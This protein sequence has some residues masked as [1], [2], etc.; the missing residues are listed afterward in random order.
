MS[1][2]V[3]GGF[4]FVAFWDIPL[5]RETEVPG[6]GGGTVVCLSCGGF[7]REGKGL[8]VIVAIRCQR[9]YFLRRVGLFMGCLAARRM[10]AG[11]YK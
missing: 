2:L 9:I 7:D 11:S 10:D 6:V 8:T 4:S 5:S 3:S 1:S